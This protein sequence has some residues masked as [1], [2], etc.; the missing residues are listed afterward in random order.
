MLGPGRGK[1]LG[2]AKLPTKLADRGLAR[3]SGE[4]IDPARQVRKAQVLVL[5]PVPVGRKLG[6]TA[7]AGFALAQLLLDALALGDVAPDALVALEA[8]LLVEDGC[9]AHAD[10]A[11]GPVQRE[12][13]IFEIAE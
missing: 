2:V 9:A 1:R 3:V 13:R 7:E 8:T 11:N 6:K 4:G 5:L 10:I 12:A